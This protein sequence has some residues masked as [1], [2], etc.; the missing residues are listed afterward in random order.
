MVQE[1]HKRSSCYEHI[2]DARTQHDA[3]TMDTATEK[4]Q[5]VM[6]RPN[7]DLEETDDKDITD[8]DFEIL[9]DETD[10]LKVVFDF[11]STFKRE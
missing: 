10:E 7:E 8:K 3:Q 11:T 9:Q 4:Q 2:R 6:Q 1:E 5:Q